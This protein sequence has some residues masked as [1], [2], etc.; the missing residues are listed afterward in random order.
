[1]NIPPRDSPKRLSKPL[2]FT[3][4]RTRFR[5]KFRYPSGMTQVEVLIST[6]LLIVVM[7]VTAM[8]FHKINLVWKD[9]RHHRIATSELA[10]QLD[11]LTRISAAKIE[12]AL[13]ELEPSKICH[14]ALPAA[15][16]SANL[17]K[18]AIG[19]RVDLEIQWR[20]GNDTGRQARPNRVRLSGWLMGGKPE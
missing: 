16:L 6:V 1:M 4:F 10:N 12:A 11:V 14:D 2:R 5:N 3:N 13:G 7:S 15:T 18:D 17:A 9:I 20:S 8:M 19:D